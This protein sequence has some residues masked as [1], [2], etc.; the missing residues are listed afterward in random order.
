MTELAGRSIVLT[1]VGREGQVGE[2]VARAFASRGARVFLVDRHVD[3]ARA[4][5]DALIAEGLRAAALGADLL[6][7]LAV[8]ALAVRLKEASGGHIQAVV[9]LAGSFA[10]SG[11]VADSDTAIWTAQLA[12][13]ATSAYLVSRAFIPLL[14]S[15][16]G[17][18]LFF[19]SEAVLPGAQMAGRSAYVASKSAVVALMQA[20]AQEEAVHGVRANALAP[21]TIRTAANVAAMGAST[22]MVS[23]E[24]VAEV[25]VWLC[26]ASARGV[27]GQ[28][29]PVR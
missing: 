10:S 21:T 26:S 18:L 25:A 20:I 29:V 3:V 8:E 27:T 23:R 7:A 14:R 13:N 4:R 28:L 12:A 16:K 19:A 5:A 2:V 11:P 9:H 24:E 1:G 17:A 15:T 6:D 22:P